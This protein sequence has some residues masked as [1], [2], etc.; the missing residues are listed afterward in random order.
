MP[1]VSAGALVILLEDQAGGKDAAAVR[2]RIAVVTAAPARPEEPYSVTLSDGRRMFAVRSRLRL[3]RAP[4]DLDPARPLS[5][6]VEH[7]LL[8]CVVYRC[9]VGSR[10]FG[11]DHADSDTDRRGFFVPPAEMHWSLYGAPE[12]IEFK[13]SEECYWEVGKF[14]RLALKANPNVLETLFTPLVEWCDPIAAEIRGARQAF[15][16]KLIYRTFHGYAVAQFEKL[17]AAAQSGKRVKWKHAMHLIRL[18]KAGRDALRTGELHLHV[19]TDRDLLLAIGAG[20]VPWPKI[21]ALRSTLHQEME[22]AHRQSGLP[23]RPDYVKAN[24]LLVEA[25]QTMTDRGPS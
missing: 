17:V 19:G 13:D 10:A 21:E 22:E 9:V 5:A 6:G 7:D 14:I 4:S 1:A 20:E 15:L 11:L 24:A 23:D 2:G 18:L 8:G 25:R 3:L 16:S 12:Q